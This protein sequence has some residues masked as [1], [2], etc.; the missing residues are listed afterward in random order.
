MP[1]I[2]QWAKKQMET[3]KHKTQMTT[4]FSTKDKITLKQNVGTALDKSQGDQELEQ[5]AM[6]ILK[7]SHLQQNALK[8]LWTQTVVDITNT[9]HE[10]AQMVLMDSNVSQDVRKKRGEGL[11]VLGEIFSS[12][13]LIDQD[14][15]QEG[16][17]EVAF[18]AMLDTIW[19][20]EK[21][22]RAH[23]KQ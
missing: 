23:Y 1:S 10:T 5:K 3:M 11:K 12:T 16:L 6:E 14:P 13:D 15:E 4:R 17:E 2:H 8:W 7:N 9:L 19:R 22:A 20:Q 18:H 21:A